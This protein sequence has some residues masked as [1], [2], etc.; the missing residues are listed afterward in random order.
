MVRLIV[1][2]VKNYR[3]TEKS[4]NRFRLEKIKTE[5]PGLGPDFWHPVI[6]GKI[7]TRCMNIYTHFRFRFHS[8]AHSLPPFSLS[9]FFLLFT[10][11]HLSFLLSTSSSFHCTPYISFSGSLLS[12][13]ASTLRH[14]HSATG[15]TPE[16]NLPV[17]RDGMLGDLFDFFRLGCL[18]CWV[19]FVFYLFGFDLSDLFVTFCFL[20]VGLCFIGEKGILERDERDLG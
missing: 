9:F 15:P 16:L 2:G 5:D 17:L 14:C 10:A 13:S 19:V 11:L 4:R 3:K 20:F 8:S 1:R 12:L 6:I 7:G 18:I